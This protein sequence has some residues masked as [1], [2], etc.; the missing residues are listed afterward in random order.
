MGQ[1]FLIANLDK[2]ELVHP[3]CLGAGLK[4][5]EICASD[6]SKVLPYLL[7]SEET[8]YEPKYLGHWFGDKIIVVGD[9]Y[10]D[11]KLY[12]EVKNYKN[13]S[14][15]LVDEFNDFIEVEEYKLPTLEQMNKED[16][17]GGRWNCFH[18]AHT[19]EN[20]KLEKIEN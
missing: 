13:I 10:K 11:G 17:L 4:L 18:C 2:K 5:W 9:Y 6:I 7:G 20:K 16:K 12:E 15:E 8:R 14:H 1:Y 19:Q 3:H